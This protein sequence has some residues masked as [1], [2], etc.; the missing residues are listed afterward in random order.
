MYLLD[1]MVV[2]DL[3]RARSGGAEPGVDPGL[4][5]W[6]AGV[7]RQ[8]LFLSALSLLELQDAAA[9]TARRDRD[10][11]T[12]L[13]Q[14]IESH[15]LPAFEGRIVPIDAAVVRRSAALAYADTRDALLVACALQRGLTLVTRDV[16]A[17]KVGR[18]K[19]F[20]PWGYMPEEHGEDWRQ[21]ARGSSQ[22]FKNLFVRA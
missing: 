12:A 15:V 19:L 8:D 17:Y 22:W 1:T 13:A 2:A 16:A 18:P 4:V 6:A 20:S 5:A 9:D 11:G 10:A 7:P 3:R 14:W 21:A